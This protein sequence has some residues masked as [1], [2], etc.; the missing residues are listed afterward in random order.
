MTPFGKKTI[1]LKFYPEKLI[2]IIENS[3]DGVR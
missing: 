3:K 2:C 1:D